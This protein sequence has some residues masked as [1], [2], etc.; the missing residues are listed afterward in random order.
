MPQ[1]AIYRLPAVLEFTGC[2]RP[3]YRL[4]NRGDFPPRV[5][6]SPPMRRLARQGHRRVARAARSGVRGVGGSGGAGGRMVLASVVSREFWRFLSSP[7]ASMQ[8]PQSRPGASLSLRPGGG[9]GPATPTRDG[10]SPAGRCA[11][12]GP[13]PARG[14]VRREYRAYRQGPQRGSLL[15]RGTPRMW[16][17]ACG[18]IAPLGNGAHHSLRGR[19]TATLA[20]RGHQTPWDA[21]KRQNS[22]D[23]TLGRRGPAAARRCCLGRRRPRIRRRRLPLARCGPAT[24]G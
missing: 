15:A 5:Q 23:T 12:S 24:R 1:I 10:T 21:L 14:V 9:S 11:P 22:R 3:P 8:A 4:I 6:L 2:P 13:C 20:W 16:I 7:C 17:A 18:G 19:A